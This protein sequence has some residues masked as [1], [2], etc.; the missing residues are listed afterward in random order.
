MLVSQNSPRQLQRDEAVLPE[1]YLFQILRQ[2]HPLYR[3]MLQP[4]W[5]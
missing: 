4:R 1:V 5:R 2:L 3:P